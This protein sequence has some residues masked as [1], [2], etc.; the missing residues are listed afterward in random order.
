[1]IMFI[2]CFYNLYVLLVLFRGNLV[3]NNPR[4]RTVFSLVGSC[5]FGLRVFS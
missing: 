5:L 2:V 3:S 1:M 4:I